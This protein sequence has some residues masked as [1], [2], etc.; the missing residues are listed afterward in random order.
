MASQTVTVLEGAKGQYEA[1]RC[2]GAA[3]DRWGIRRNSRSPADGIGAED[4]CNAIEDAGIGYD[5]P[6]LGALGMVFID[7]IRDRPLF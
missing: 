5:I 3:L 7:G 1:S 2:Q 6:Y 4:G